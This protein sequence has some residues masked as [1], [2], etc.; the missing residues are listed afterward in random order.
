MTTFELH[1]PIENTEHSPLQ[2]L[3]IQCEL[4]G[5]KLS[6]SELKQAIQKGALWVTRKKSTSRLRRVKKPLNIGDALHFYYNKQ[7]LQQVSPQAQLIADH[8]DYSI[9]YKPFSMLSQGSKWSDHCTIAR[10]AQQYFML[11]GMSERSCFIIHRLDRAA[12]GL[13]IIA[14]TKKAAQALSALFEKHDLEKY[15]HIIVQGRF[16]EESEEN[17]PTIIST[18]VDNKTALSIFS[19]I[20]YDETKD[21]S[22]L[23]V[24]IE[25]GRKHQIR[26]HAASIGLPV[27]GDRLHGNAKKEE[28]NLQLC[29]V[30]LAFACPL[31]N[32]PREYNL[33]E[34]LRPSLA[35]IN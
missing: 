27:L 28:V 32:E 23:N 13:I 4:S 5:N 18:D 29:A 2:I 20:E 19:L 25:T 17:H 10:Y 1:I 22:L 15:Y 3:A 6:N 11:E 21:L 9:W 12:S 30:K 24:K 7:V 33:P 26:I 14:H 16:N 35:N 34:K 8:K 31:T